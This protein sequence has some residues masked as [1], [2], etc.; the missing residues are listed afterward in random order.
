MDSNSINCDTF[1]LQDLFIYFFNRSD[2]VIFLEGVGQLKVTH[3]K[4]L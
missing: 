4:I 2:K 3:V 1:N